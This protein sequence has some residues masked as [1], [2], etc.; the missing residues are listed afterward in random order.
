MTDADTQKELEDLKRQVA[1]LSA[2][3]RTR[4]KAAPQPEVQTEPAAESTT[5]EDRSIASQ[6]EE[7]VGLLESELR[8]HPMVRGAAIFVAGLIVGRM[9]R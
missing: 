9:L 7:L 3:R 8:D 1:A 2:A 4:G 5:T 6:V